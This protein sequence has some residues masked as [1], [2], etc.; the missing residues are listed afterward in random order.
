MR[1]T[2]H[3]DY[4]L[5][6]LMSLAVAGGE[7][8]TIEDLSRRHDVSNNHLM[9]VTR[10]LTHA[11]FVRGVRGRNGG[12]ELAR[13]PEDIVI[14]DVVRACEENF[15]LVDCFDARADR[16][17]LT[18]ACGLR[19]PLQEALAAFL[20]VLDRYTLEDLT[21]RPSQLLALRRLVFPEAP[22]PTA[23]QQR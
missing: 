12:L 19:G 5:R 15:A 7:R 9:K 22:E 10:T 3:T 16:C 8:Q 20:A 4:A 11:G 2:L 18:P 17:L 21:A 23:D 13:P 6:F 14:G 1:L